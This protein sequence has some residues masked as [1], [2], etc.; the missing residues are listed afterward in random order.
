MKG[1]CNE[2]NLFINLY[3]G[4]AYEYYF[5]SKDY[6][7]LPNF[8]EIKTKDQFRIRMNKFWNYES[9][10]RKKITFVNIPN[11]NEIEKTMTDNNN[12]FLKI[13]TC[14]ENKKI[15]YGTFL[16]DNL[17]IN[18]KEK[19][20]MNEDVAKFIEDIIIDVKK[21]INGKVEKKSLYKYIHK[22]DL[23]IQK[24]LNKDFGPYYFPDDKDCF[25]Y[26]N[27]LSILYILYYAGESRWERLLKS[28]FEIL[29]QIKQSNLIFSEK[30][31]LLIS[32][33]RKAFDSDLIIFPT[34]KFFDKKNIAKDAYTKAYYFHLDLI[35]NLKEE[36]LLMIQF[37]QLNSYIMDR[38]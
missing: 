32:I 15:E 38:I 5:I 11:Q 10:N 13:Y 36:S 1:Y 21:Y 19:F 29:E 6:K 25:D 33:V 14:D 18:Q 27:R 8:I 22:V 16:L 12:S 7:Y 20:L 2:I 31:N 3:G 34:I 28:Y 37:L 24:E 17:K 9:T 35:D 4:Y 30:I 26:F 23:E